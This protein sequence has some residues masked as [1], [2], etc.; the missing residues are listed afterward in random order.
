M[1]PDAARAGKPP[2]PPEVAGVL[3]RL[4]ATL[5]RLPERATPAGWATAWEQLAAETGLLAAMDR[6][7]VLHGDCPSFRAAGDC[8]NFRA[9]GDCPNFRAAKMGLS[10]SPTPQSPQ[11]ADRVAW[12]RLV[13]ALTAADRLAAWMDR[14]PPELDRREALAALLDILAGERVGSSGDESGRVRVLSAASVR[15]LRIPYVFLA[16]LSEKAFPPPDRDD[17]L[18]SEAEYL[19]LIDEGLPLVARTERNREEMLLFYE[20]MTRATRRLIL[21]YPAWDESAQPLS[22][23]PYLHAVEQAC[24]PGRIAR[25]ELVD[26]T[27]V[28]VRGGKGPKAKGTV[29]FSL[30]ENWDSPPLRENWDSPPDP[31]TP[32]EFRV[33]SLAEALEGDVSLLAGLVQSEPAPGLAAN[34]LAGLETTRLRSDRERFGPAEGV[35]EGEAARRHL[36]ERF[37]AERTLSPTMLEGYA[38]CPFRFFMERVLGIEPLEELALTVDFMER[39]R[40]AHDVM[41]A[42][43]RRVNEA[44]G[45]PGSP[46]ELD[47][48]EYEPLLAAA[49]DE[50][51]PPKAAGGVRATMVEVDR[52]LL[53]SWLADY[54]RQHEKYDAL[55]EAC[56]EPPVPEL[57]EVSFGRPG[58]GEGPSIEEPF[59]LETEGGLVRISGRVDRIDVGRVA[60]TAVFNVIDYKTGSPL[61]FSEETIRAGTTLQLPLYAFAV[62]EVL[63]AGR[64]PV[65]WTVGYWYLR[66]RG[67]KPDK[68]G[69]LYEPSDA[70]V[71]PSESWEQIR[72]ELAGIVGRLVRGMRCGEFPV[73]SQDERCTSFCPFST[74]CRIGQVRALEKT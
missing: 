39:G 10:P 67:F 65:P 59:V 41:A 16:G 50:V 73:S 15:G 63:L 71:E 68:C 42:L 53:R 61:K 27:P 40:L 54:R 30:R 13:D 70:G 24:G 56:D 11:I 9:A 62:A 7:G 18:Y 17:R 21:S 57:F 23:S 46:L 45:R 31:L 51:L 55:F 19:R 44:L 36:A 4:A 38:T 34:T 49:L 47:P 64:N 32:A 1:P 8:P 74:I 48:A 69:R 29:P 43:H 33:A 25:T 14:H 26:L 72:M 20:A 37:S 66:D 28:P 35:F 22:P 52:R 58:C 2:M 5:D 3:G 6:P 60:G 12:A